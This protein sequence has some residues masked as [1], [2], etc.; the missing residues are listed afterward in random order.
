M[1]RLPGDRPERQK[2][3]HGADGRH[4]FPHPRAYATRKSEWTAWDRRYA[5]H[6]DRHKELVDNPEPQPGDSPAVLALFDHISEQQSI[7]AKEKQLIHVLRQRAAE[8]PEA[9]DLW[10][11]EELRQRIRRGRA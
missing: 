11:A 1:T 2:N 9:D 3:F 4:L 6:L 7:I 10:Q 8:H 5:A